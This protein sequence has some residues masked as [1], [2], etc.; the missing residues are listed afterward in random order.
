FWLRTMEPV[1]I[2]ST[3][4]FSSLFRLVAVFGMALMIFSLASS[5]LTVSAQDATPDEAQRELEDLRFF[6][7]YIPNIQ[8]SPLY[9]TAAKGYFAER[10]LNILIE[11]GDENVG[12]EQI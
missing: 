12:V 5:G 1:T 7:S 6:L 4:I 8:F 10:G 3:R 9:V 11:H 2:M